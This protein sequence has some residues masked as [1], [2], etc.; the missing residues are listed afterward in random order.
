[1]AG[2]RKFLGRNNVV[3]AASGVVIDMQHWGAVTFVGYE[4]GGATDVVL[5]EHDDDGANE[6]ALDLL[7]VWHTSNGI[8]GAW[9]EQTESSATGTLEPSDATAQDGWAVTIAAEDL[10][11]GYRYVECTPDGGTCFAILHDGH[12][13]RQPAVLPVAT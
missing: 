7:H 12:V 10:S 13:G 1:M 3:P 2:P 9:T 4:D 5:T 6:Q 11:D 8:G